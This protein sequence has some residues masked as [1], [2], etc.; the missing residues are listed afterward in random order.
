MTTTPEATITRD[1]AGRGTARWFDICSY[2]DLIPERGVCAMVDGVQVAVFRVYDGALYAL[3]NLDPF[4]GAYVLSRGILGTRDGTPTVAS[5]MY[6]QVFDLRTG[7]CLDDPRV[8]L[9]A[10]PVRRAGDRV[11][12]ALTDEHRQ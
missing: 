11:E 5:P 4:S 12:V 3:S 8:A 1:P 2:A 10:F 9:P 7:A 6:K